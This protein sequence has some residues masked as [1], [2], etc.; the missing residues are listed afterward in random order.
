MSE[1]L[2]EGAKV[3]IEPDE[4]EEQHGT[5]IIPASVRDKHQHAQ[6]MGTVIAVGPTA[7]T[8]VEIDGEKRPVRAGDRVMI[9]KHSYVEY[10]DG[11]TRKKRWIVYDDDILGVVK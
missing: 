10:S 6:Q 2:P 4:M 11:E 3:V 8:Y 1:F 7:D 9:I 5:I